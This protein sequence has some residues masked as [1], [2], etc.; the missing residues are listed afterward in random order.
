[1]KH[2]VKCYGVIYGVIRPLDLSDERLVK[3]TTMISFDINIYLSLVILLFESNV[4]T[5]LVLYP[6]STFEYD[7][8]FFVF[9]QCMV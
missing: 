6:I 5:N 2:T 7:I 1:M 8:D 4:F 9:K 3:S